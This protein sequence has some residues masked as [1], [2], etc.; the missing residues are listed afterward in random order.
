MFLTIGIFAPFLSF[1]MKKN[2]F[3]GG[4]RD[5]PG[6]DETGVV[7]RLATKIDRLLVGQVSAANP[8]GM[9][10][11]HVLASCL[12]CMSLLHLEATCRCTRPCRRSMPHVH[13]AYPCHMSILLVYAACHC[14]FSILYV[15]S[16]CLC[17][18]SL[19]YVL[20]SRPCCL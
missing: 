11:L 14:C 19:L 10:K 1:V 9:S 12:C 8:C 3:L 4:K 5:I 6:A 18:I 13:A 2:Y 20:A 16:V 15:H 17:R 7:L